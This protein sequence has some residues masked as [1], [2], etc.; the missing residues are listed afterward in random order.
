VSLFGEP[1]NVVKERQELG[2]GQEVF[3]EEMGGTGE[4]GVEGEAMETGAVRRVYGWIGEACVDGSS[5]Y[6]CQIWSYGATP[7]MRFPQLPSVEPND[8]SLAR[9][10]GLT[11]FNSEA[12]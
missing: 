10:S 11:A 2:G 4:D 9:A 8:A 5:D 3:E 12:I 6:G 7:T 1:W